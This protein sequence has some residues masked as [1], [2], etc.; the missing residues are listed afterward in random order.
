VAGN[1]KEPSRDVKFIQLWSDANFDPAAKS[2]CAS[3]AGF[4]PKVAG[5]TTGR[6]VS[7]LI[8][9]QKMQ[10]ELKK[11]GV[12]MKVLAKKIVALLDARSPLGKPTKDP[13]T[14]ELTYPPDNFVQLKAT[15]LGLK[16]HDAFAPTR[17]DV[18]KTETKQIIFSAEVLHRLERFDSQREAMAKAEAI[19][20]TPE[21]NNQE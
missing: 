10:K 14:G 5:R 4:S 20:V 6:I 16:L 11:A 12:D 15:E 8:Q 17:I 9:N 13:V 7:S 21:P 18:D 1:G 2:I 19:D 3:R